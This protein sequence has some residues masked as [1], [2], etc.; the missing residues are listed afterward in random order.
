MIM[1]YKFKKNLF[2]EL[3]YIHVYEYYVKMAVIFLTT[4][5]NEKVDP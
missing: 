4:I 3:P 1:T 2:F 5:F